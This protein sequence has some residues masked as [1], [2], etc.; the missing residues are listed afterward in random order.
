MAIV[1]I[2]GATM[3]APRMGATGICLSVFIAYMVRTIGMEIIFYKDLHLDIFTF[4]KE[5]FIRMT[6]ALLLCVIIGFALQYV[7][8][9]GNWY[10]L[11]IKGIIFCASFWVIMYFLAMNQSEKQLLI[12]PF[13]KNED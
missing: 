4:F 13:K 6:P 5:S 9:I 1:N 10:Y 8:P 11:T 2:L 7:I 3:L 12:T